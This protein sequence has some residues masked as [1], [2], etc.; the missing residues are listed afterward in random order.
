[1]YS[2]I[3]RYCYDLHM[4]NNL[5][6]IRQKDL[7]TLKKLKKALINKRSQLLNVLLELK[8]KGLNERQICL[9]IDIKYDNYRYL[10]NKEELKDIKEQLSRAR[11][12]S[13][14]RRKED[15]LRKTIRNVD[16]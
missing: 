3:D 7:K 9:M 13:K 12:Y 8:S 5:E 2:Y 11:L 6:K 10:I 4:Y 16:I 15:N 14:V 1:M